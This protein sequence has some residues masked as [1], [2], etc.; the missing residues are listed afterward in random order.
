MKAT[1]SKRW[2]GWLIAGL[3]VVVAAG[4]AI[5]G[6]AAAFRAGAVGS[7]GLRPLVRAATSPFFLRMA[8]VAGG[9]LAAIIGMGFLLARA[10]RRQR[11][12][13]ASLASS[14]TGTTMVEFA[15]VLPIAT[16]VV[17]MLVQSM[18]MMA[19]SIV[20]NYA[21]SAAARAAIVWV[22]KDL[23]G[24]APWTP[25]PYNTVTDAAN[26]EQ[27]QKRSTI[28]LAASVALLPVAGIS[29][30]DAD[31]TNGVFAPGVVQYFTAQNA[32]Q[33]GW[34][35][36]F[37]PGKLNYAWA[38]TTATLQPGQALPNAY[39]PNEDLTVLVQHALVLPV[40]Y[41]NMLFQD[42]SVANVGYTANVWATSTLN[43]EGVDSR[44]QEDVFR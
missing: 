25:E 40:P 38:H 34:T 8:A 4:P 33:P 41:A 23:G 27:S 10:G 39:Q 22:P 44:I 30:S 32:Q 43:N 36:N 18:L 16:A 6:L 24:V 19:G 37:L 14:E 31:P 5:F 21:A 11:L 12:Q 9:S 42:G 15:L 28:K 26:S 2:A 20:V 17:L 1:R 3:V 7:A 35:T 13:R 29:P